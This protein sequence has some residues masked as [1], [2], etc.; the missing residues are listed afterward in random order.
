MVL[1]GWVARR[2]DHGGL[3]FIDLRD[4]YGITQLVFDPAISGSQK[5]KE[6]A[7]SVRGEFVISIKGVVRRRPEDMVNPKISTG[8]IEISVSE[9]HVLSS[10]K[11][12]PFL[13]DDHTDAGEV[14]RLKHRYLDLR[15]PSLQKNLIVRHQT[16]Q[17]VRRWI[18]RGAP[19]GGILHGIH[20]ES[21]L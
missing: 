5:S 13:I 15:R 18:E 3:I 4:R 2:R 20:R 12:P 9:L 10:A 21:S 7:E 8:E 14:L 1:A 19:L 17:V 6:A 16:Y 11:T